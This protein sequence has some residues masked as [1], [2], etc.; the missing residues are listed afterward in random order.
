MVV[1]ETIAC[2]VSAM[3]FFLSFDPTLTANNFGLKPLNLGKYTFLG[4]SG[5]QLS[6][7][8]SWLGHT[9]G[10]VVNLHLHPQLL[11]VYIQNKY[12]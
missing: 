4:S 8:L 2:D 12:M 1:K 5:H 3:S 9:G 7:G 11:A 6:H 10:K